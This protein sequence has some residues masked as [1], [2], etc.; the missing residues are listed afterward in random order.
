MRSWS[1][2]FTIEFIEL[3]RSLPCLYDVKNKKYLNKPLKTAAYNELVEKLKT[4]DVAAT[5]DTV[6]KKIN[7]MRSSYRKELKKMK[8][9]KRSGS[10]GDMYETSLWYFHNLDFL[11]EHEIPRNS[12]SNIIQ[13]VDSNVS[14]I[15]G[16]SSYFHKIFL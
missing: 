1:H 3:Y 9:S 10:S 14:D 8:E 5:K 2:E 16:V 15:D 13:D 12:K 4:I 11:Y 7:N 6:V